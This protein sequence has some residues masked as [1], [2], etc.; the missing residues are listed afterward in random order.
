MNTLS[1]TQ[2]L[3]YWEDAVKNPDRYLVYD[4]EPIKNPDWD[5]PAKELSTLGQYMDDNKI[6]VDESDY[7]KLATR[8]AERYREI[9][10]INPRKVSRTNDSGK[11][12]NKSYAYS[13]G[14]FSIIEECL[15]TV[16]HT[17]LP[18]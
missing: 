7:H 1:K 4:V 16:R 14:S 2:L 18:K 5:I 10:G 9:Y 12:N 13:Q 3:G 15:L 11:W 6:I 8:L 17:R